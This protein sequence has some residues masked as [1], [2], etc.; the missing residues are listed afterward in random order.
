MAEKIFH[1][2]YITEKRLRTTGLD[3]DNNNAI[4]LFSAFDA[5][6]SK[7]VNR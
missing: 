5:S 1:R 4:G 2:G 7:H 3:N 6:E